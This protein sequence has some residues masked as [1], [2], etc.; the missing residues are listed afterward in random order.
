MGNKL[1]NNGSIQYLEDRAK[2]NPN[3]R[4]RQ[5]DV[6]MDGKIAW[7]GKFVFSD[8]E[9]TVI[10][11]SIM[12]KRCHRVSLESKKRDLG[13]AVYNREMMNQ[14]LS[15]ETRE[16]KWR[17]LENVFTDEDIKY[18]NCNRFIAID[19]N[20]GA[21]MIKGSD[22]DPLGIVV[23]D[24]D[25]EN[26]WYVQYARQLYLDLPKLIDQ[27]FYLW[28]TYH[29]IRIGVEKLSFEYQVRPYLTQKSAE[30]GVFPVV[31][32]LKHG[33]RNKEDRIRGA[34]MGRLAN[35][36]IFFRK[37]AIDDTNALCTELF[38]FPE[39]RHDDLSDALAY[40]DQI[41]YKPMGGKD[42]R[43]L[44]SIEDEMRHYQKEQKGLKDGNGYLANML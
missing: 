20:Q 34:L 30:T 41:G 9:A 19:T 39:A 23:V 3:W 21:K 4:H 40:I 31:E 2:K 7:P 44:T 1:I 28:E 25:G 10:N 18:K 32:E 37:D 36:R 8:A 43:L 42:E 11:S 26:N 17:W 15:D 14:P 38:D 13:L 33:G 5:V 27:I 35:G 22:P 16:V 29:P 24:W 12:E 6:V